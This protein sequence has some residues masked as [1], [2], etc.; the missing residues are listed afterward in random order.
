MQQ[1][2]QAWQWIDLELP[3]QQPA[4][5][6][7]RALQALIDSHV[8]KLIRSGDVAAATAMQRI[9]LGFVAAQSDLQPRVFWRFCAA[10]FEAISAGLCPVDVKG[11][12]A[13]SGILL[14]YRVLAGGE[15]SVSESLLRDVLSLLAQVDANSVPDGSALAAVRQAYGLAAAKLED[16]VREIGGL[17]IGVSDFNAYLNASDEWSRRL[18]MELSEWALELHLPLPS[19]TVGWAHSLATGS[20]DIGL[21]ALS[22]LAGLLEQALRHVQ[23]HVPVRPEHV[24][25]LLAAADEIR[26]LLHQFAA[27]FLK[28]P[29]TGLLKTLRD[30]V[31]FEFSASADG[32][33]A[34]I[35]P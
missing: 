9:S 5:L 32:A 7:D 30:I 2:M 22:E 17:R 35:R 31:Q 4:R 25:V 6:Y 18:F 11:K 26:R 28:Q 34:A 29:E 3:A 20:A 33:D 27:G 8:L 19:A 1:L 14:Q 24:M 16:Q 13:L 12:R 15:R 10:Y 23:S 21:H